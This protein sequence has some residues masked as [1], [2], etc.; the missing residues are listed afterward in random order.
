MSAFWAKAVGAPAPSPVQ[1]LA[2]VAQPQMQPATPPPPSGPPRSVQTA[3]ANGGCPNCGSGNYTASPADP[4]IRP[5]C[6]DCGFPVL[7]S[8]S[9]VVTTQGTDK[10]APS[11]QVSTRNNFN[12]QQIV[13]R[14]G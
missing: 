1:T 14:I 9:G 12:P 13:G 8:T 4:N 3:S 5:R 7:H 2:P 10:T 11:R 6:Y